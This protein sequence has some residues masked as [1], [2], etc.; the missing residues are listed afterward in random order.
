MIILKSPLLETLPWLYHGFFT[1]S[2][3]YSK[4]VFSS[5]NLSYSVGDN[6]KIVDK[7]WEKMKD[8]LPFK[9]IHLLKQVHSDIIVETKKLLGN[10]HS[11]IGEGDGLISSKTGLGVGMLTADCVP[12]LIADIKERKVAAVHSGWR[13]AVKRISTKTIKKMGSKKENLRIVLG[14]A[15]CDKCY[16]VGYDVIEQVNKLGYTNKDIYLNKG[17]KYLLNM[18][19]LVEEE[20]VNFG[21]S[22]INIFL[23]K[24]CTKCN[25]MLYSYRKSRQTGRQLSVIGI[26]K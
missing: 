20:L 19:K 1:N 15:I 18:Q 16:E 21:I 3:G 26:I 4:G 7:N 12:V 23:V 22:P 25:A 11:V 13:G 6:N 17:D 2:G 10:S 8:V 5:L 14:P 9:E 24:C